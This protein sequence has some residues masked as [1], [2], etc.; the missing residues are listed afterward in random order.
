MWGKDN[1]GSNQ[2][3]SSGD[4]EKCSAYIFKTKA[5]RF[6]EGLDVGMRKQFKDGHKVFGLIDSKKDGK[7]HSW[8]WEEQLHEIRSLRL[9][10]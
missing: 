3:C 7:C 8:R 5:R 2:D 10:Y 9:G 6:A 4:G 1:S